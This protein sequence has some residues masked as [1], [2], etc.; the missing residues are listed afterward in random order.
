MFL[1]CDAHGVMPP[2]ARLSPAQSAYHFLSGYTARVAGTERGVS[3]PTATFSTCF[4]APFLPLPAGTYAAL[5]GEKIERHNVTCWLVNT[6]WTEGAYG[7]GRRI[8]LEHT[9]A[10]VHAALNGA[11]DG[12]P[13][14]REPVFG[15]EVPREVP[16]VPRALLLPRATWADPSAYD[17]RAAHV[18]E[19][20]RQNFTQFADHV[21][22][23]VREAGPTA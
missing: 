11:L 3:E 13:T 6:G 2:I 20:F 1:T 21:A 5:L 9:R 8:A 23:P 4:A 16:Q 22:S 7:L 12:V 18:A 10:M 17:A 19:L 14:T 15:L